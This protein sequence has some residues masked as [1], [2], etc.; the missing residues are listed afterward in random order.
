M[1]MQ[2]PPALCMVG[3]ALLL[4]VLCATLRDAPADHEVLAWWGVA[5]VVFAIVFH[6]GAIAPEERRSRGLAAL[7]VLTVAMLAMAAIMPCQF[8]ALSLVIVVF[9]CWS[10][11]APGDRLDRRS[12]ARPGLVRV[13]GL[14]AGGHD[15]PDHQPARVRYAAVA[16]LL[17]RRERRPAARSRTSTPSSA[18]PGHSSRRPAASRS[19]RGSRA[20]STTSSGT[21]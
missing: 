8:G 14:R 6:V 5:F 12:D 1:R 11:P 10:V 7:A 13:G 16:V 19:A 3:Y 4:V 21:T 2:L 15:R 17:M 9:I 20:S 18:R